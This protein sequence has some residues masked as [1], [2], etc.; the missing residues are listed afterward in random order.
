MRVVFERCCAEQQDVPSQCGDRRNRA[1][2]GLARVSRR[3]PQVLR[4]VH[5]Q[6]VDPR[7][8]RLPRQLGPLDQRFERDHRA[9][10]D[11]ERIEAGA[12]VALDVSQP[13]CVEQREHLVILAPQLA[14]PLHR[15]C[16]GRDDEAALDFS[17]VQQA[18]HDERRLDRLAESDFVGQQP[19]HR[20]PRRRALG[21]V[22]LV[23]EEANASAEEGAEAA[24]LPHGQQVQD[25]EVRQEVVGLV[26]LAGRQAVDQRQFATPFPLGLADQRLAVGR[27]PQRRRRELDCDDAAFDSGDAAGAQLGVEAVGDMV[28]HGPGVHVSMLPRAARPT[29]VE[30]SADFSVRCG[31]LLSGC[32][33]RLDVACMAT[34]PAILE[35]GARARHVSISHDFVLEA[36]VRGTRDPETLRRRP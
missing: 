28:P 20:H 35:P 16:L 9:G 30:R 15:Q 7:V 2:A 29:G 18:V 34:L 24:R 26:D 17:G 32:K 31:H 21:D 11:V 25:V 5:D 3:T 13:R 33:R 6:E 27:K 4:L 22:H 36:L 8:H 14:E 10:V 1:V 12:E 23:R 19:P